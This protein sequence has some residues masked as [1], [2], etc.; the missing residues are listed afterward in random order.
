[1]SDVH[2]RTTDDEPRSPVPERFQSLNVPDG[3]LV[4]YDR[5][6]HERWLQSDVP[7]DLDEMR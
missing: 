7:V 5:D 1:M 4:I 2:P 3:R 6:G